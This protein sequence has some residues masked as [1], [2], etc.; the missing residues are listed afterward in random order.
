MGFSYGFRPGR[1]PHNAW[2]AL[3]VG[4]EQKW[5][6]RVLDAD[7][8]AYFDTISN[9]LLVKFIDHR[10]GDRRMIDLIQKWLKAGVLEE[11]QL[12]QNEEG[13]PQGGVISPVLANIYLHYAFDLW[14]HQWRKQQA[15]GE[16]IL[17]VMPMTLWWDLN[18]AMK[19]NGSGT[20]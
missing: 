4:I 16:V 14:A 12:T 20:I 1:G 19:P 2:D 11:G 6:G 17:G 9:E 15:R 13:T 3:T 8:R 5:V 18:T 10:I 7:I